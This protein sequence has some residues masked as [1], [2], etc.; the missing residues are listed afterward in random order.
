[1]PDIDDL[2]QVLRISFW[3]HKKYP[4]PCKFC[5]LSE[6]EPM[7]YS[8]KERLGHSKFAIY[9]E[10]SIKYSF[11]EWPEDFEEDLRTTALPTADLAADLTTQVCLSV[12]L[13]PFLSVSLFLSLSVICL[14]VCLYP[15]SGW[16]LPRNCSRFVNHQIGLQILSQHINQFIQNVA[17]HENETIKILVCTLYLTLHP[18]VGLQKYKIQ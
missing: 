18:I 3:K 1:M 15:S 13:L 17:Q 14:S 16:N 11:K 8:V 4:C 9:V 10:K 6:S 12:C 7:Q 5:N 2:M